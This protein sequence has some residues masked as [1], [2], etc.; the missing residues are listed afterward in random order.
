VLAGRVFEFCE[1]GFRWRRECKEERGF[2]RGGSRRKEGGSFG[3]EVVDEQ[4]LLGVK[5]R[6]RLM[7][8]EKIRCRE[9]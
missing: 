4:G 9:T 6:G 3:L 7:E 2:G 8:E 5:G 1:E